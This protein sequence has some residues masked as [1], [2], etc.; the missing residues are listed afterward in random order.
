MEMANAGNAPAAGAVLILTLPMSVTPV[1]AQPT[2]SWTTTSVIFAGD[3]LG[4]DLGDLSV[5]E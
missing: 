5:G 2:P 1:S 4:W 3:V